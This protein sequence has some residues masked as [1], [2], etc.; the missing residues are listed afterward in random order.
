MGGLWGTAAGLGLN[1]DVIDFE[2]GQQLRA[3]LGNEVIGGAAGLHDD[4]DT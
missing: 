4:M 3:Q 1:G 2:L